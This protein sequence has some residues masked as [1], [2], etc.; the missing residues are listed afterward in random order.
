M[1]T[2]GLI[3]RAAILGYR[4]VA[5]ASGTTA[6]VLQMAK[7]LGFAPDELVVLRATMAA[8]MLPT[9]DHSFFE[10]MLGGEPYMPASCKMAIGRDDLGQLWPPG[11]TLHT[12]GGSFTS[13][14]VWAAVGKRFAA[15]AQGR[16]L[17]GKLAKSDPAAHA[18]VEKLLGDD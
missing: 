3:G 4:L 11:K 7:L 10:I 1:V 5:G 16:A 14:S 6:N 12:S 9:N 13:D 15:T 17:L 2:P 18:Y 8:W